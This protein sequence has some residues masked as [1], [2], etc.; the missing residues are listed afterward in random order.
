MWS[1]DGADCRRHAPPC[2]RLQATY[3]SNLRA[4]GGKPRGCRR[5]LRLADA[6][7][8]FASPRRH[9]RGARD[10]KKEPM[11]M[12]EKN[13]RGSEP[14]ELV[15]P[16]ELETVSRPE[17]G[18]PARSP[19]D[20]EVLGRDVGRQVAFGVTPAVAGALVLFYI[21]ATSASMLAGA[22]LI[23]VAVKA[24]S[25][26]REPLS[27]RRRTQ[28]RITPSTVF[29]GEEAIDRYRLTCS[30]SHEAS[31]GGVVDDRQADRDNRAMVLTLRRPWRLPITLRLSCRNKDSIS[32][33][34]R[35]PDVE[36][37]GT[38]PPIAFLKGQSQIVLAVLGVAYL[39]AVYGLAVSVGAL[40]TYALVGGSLLALT[41]IEGA[42]HVGRD[43]IVIRSMVSTLR[44]PLADVS[45]IE[46]G[47][48]HGGVAQVLLKLGEGQKEVALPFG[49]ERCTASLAD[50]VAA[51]L[52][53]RRRA[54]PEAGTS[55]GGGSYRSSPPSGG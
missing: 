1:T 10:E 37:L 21:G 9:A 36:V 29:V 16:G 18:G 17:G 45:S 39:G 2:A 47:T 7:M 55:V 28:L 34:L 11:T 26:M 8:P 43:S 4:S 23:V 13:H 41:A 50:R 40:V 35:A 53:Q 30:V 24:F 31:G 49:A 52:R 22:L 54:L 32:E 19:V 3:G 12:E 38:L 33:L 48:G 27:V 5:L 25:L 20:V 14:I 6:S 15:D 44:I 46:R 42:V 51:S